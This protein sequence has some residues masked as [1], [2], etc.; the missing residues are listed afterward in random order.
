MLRV[1]NI[2]WT[3]SRHELAL[4]F[5]RF[6]YVHDASVA[7]DRQSGLNQGYGHVT[8]LK[9]A[10]ADSVLGCEHFL[11]GKYLVVSSVKRQG[12]V[13]VNDDNNLY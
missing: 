3:I 12:G 2:P 8:F 9:K 6:G 11:E 7:F 4:Y 5:S 1:T 13:N 10:Q